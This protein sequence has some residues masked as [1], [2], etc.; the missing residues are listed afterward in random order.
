MRI[1]W[2]KA[3]RLL[4]VDTG[5][6]IRSYNILKHLARTNELTFC[7]Y[8]G[9]SRDVD[10]EV[11]IRR[12]FAGAMVIHTG[13][14]ESAPAKGLHYLLHAFDRAPY[15]VSKFTS[16]K[17]RRLITESFE[18]R[19]FDVA[20]CDF[21]SASLNFPDDL[22]V[23]SVLFQHNVESALWRRQDKHESNPIKRLAFKLEAKKMQRY[24]AATVGRFHHVIAV[25]ENDREQMNAMTDPSRI[26]VVPTGVDLAQYSAAAGTKPDPRLVIFLGSMDWEANIDGVDYFCRDMWPRIRS[27]IPEARLRIVGRNPHPRVKRLAGESIEVTGTVSNVIEHLKQAAVV[28]VPLRIGGG[29]RLKIYEAMAMGKAVVSTTIGAEGLDVE[30]GRNILLADTEAGFAQSVISLLCDAQLRRR[31]EAAAQELAARYDW[32]VIARR[33]EEVLECVAHASSSEQPRQAAAAA[34]NS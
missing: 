15:A 11:Q 19:K 24:E 20:V 6:K 23:P 10:Y 16:T 17:V 32:S 1:L 4:P 3:G 28:V 25:S 12:C 26:S 7:S 31:I 8:Y 18:E 34:G 9:G 30:H 13:A 14:P 21:L 27:A 2:V 5:G 22:A 29:T 33:F